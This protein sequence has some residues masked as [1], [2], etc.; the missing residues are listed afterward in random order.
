MR[1]LFLSASGQ[2]GGAE[3]CM[4]DLISV[5]RLIEPAWELGLIAAQAGPL[6][7]DAGRMN[8][9]TAVVPFP[10]ALGRLGDSILR[11]DSSLGAQFAWA[12]ALPRATI[13]AVQYKRRLRAVVRSF[14]PTLI[15]AN[16]FKMQVMAAR[17]RSRETSV[18]WHIHD[19]VS[20]RMIMKKLLRIHAGK[21]DVAVANSESVASDVRTTVKTL[22][23][24]DA[25]LNGVDLERFSPNGSMLDL[26]AMAG[27][28]ACPP[29]FVKVGLMATF[30]RWKG[31]SVFLRAISELD[32]ALPFRAYVIGGPLYQTAGSQ[33]V[34][35]DLKQLVKDLGIED[36]VGFTGYCRERA[37]ALRSLDVVVHA[38]TEPEP[39]GM[40][41]AEA[42]SCGRAIIAAGAG[43]VNEIVNNRLDGLTHEPGNSTDLA[44]KMEL[45]IRDATVRRRL[46]TR[47][48]ESASLRFDRTRVAYQFRDLYRGIMVNKQ[49]SRPGGTSRIEIQSHREGRVSDE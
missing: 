24:V 33:V 29:Q 48:R 30:A 8:V 20:P 31:H 35:Q 28:P 43:G 36:R 19:Y 25:I 13:H 37:K 34:L 17:L 23:K 32:P 42:M 45:L 38:S 11:E 39:F 9:W 27:L 7:D 12:A 46:G 4:L 10:A 1:L 2:L 14:S 22:H 18:V 3:V 16:G 6:L 49:V 21:C 15:H 5:L 40:V 47:A 44:S 41:I 26:D